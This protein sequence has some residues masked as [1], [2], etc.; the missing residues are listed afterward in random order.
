MSRM[1]IPASIEAAPE[2]SQ[3]LLAGVRQQLGSVPNAFRLIGNSPAAL[4]GFLGLFGG[5]EKGK[6][7]PETRKRIAIAIAE[8]NGCEY[9]LS[10]HAYTGRHTVKLDVT[11]ICANR[12]GASNDPF[13]DAAVRFAVQVART[14]GRVTAEELAAVREA[15]YDDTQVIE[16]VAHVA[17]NIL[18]NYTNEVAATEID[19]PVIH[20]RKMA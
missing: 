7:A 12:S 19:F 6:L 15:G 4:E 14:K 11:E 5:L 3:P 13:A 2:A 17:L 18:T 8:F 1:N 16:I 9:C 10:S 20:R